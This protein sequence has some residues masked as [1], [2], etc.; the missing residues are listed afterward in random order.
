M[1]RTGQTLSLYDHVI[2]VVSKTHK[3]FCIPT[4]AEHDRVDQVE[5]PRGRLASVLGSHTPPTCY[6]SHS[7][8]K[9]LGY[10]MSL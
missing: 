5:H 8:S 6:Y 3:I 2:N 7:V 10:V 4:Q 1:Q 9:F